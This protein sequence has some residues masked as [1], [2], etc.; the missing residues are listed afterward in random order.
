MI[1]HV[2][3]TNYNFYAVKVFTCGVKTSLAFKVQLL[4]Y[5]FLLFFNAG[6]LAKYT[7][8]QVYYY[9]SFQSA[10]HG[11]KLRKEL[12]RDLTRE[13]AWE[14]VMRIRCGKGQFM[15]PRNSLCPL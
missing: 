13:T 4:V 3:T 7:G 1:C 14:A 12:T 6:T 11:D 10:T 8:G 5:F 2:S 15:M 9:P